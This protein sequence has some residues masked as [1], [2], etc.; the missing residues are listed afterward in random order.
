MLAVAI[1]LAA[2]SGGCSAFLTPAPAVASSPAPPACSTSY[3][4]PALDAA[5]ATGAAIVAYQTWPLRGACGNASCPP[6]SG[7]G[8]PL[9]AMVWIG[10]PLGYAASAVRGGRIVAVCRR[11]RRELTAAHA[12]WLAQQRAFAD[13]SAAIVA[14]R[15]DDCG[16]ALALPPGPGGV[17]ADPAVAQCRA[18][19]TERRR[20]AAAASARLA[21]VATGL[22]PAVRAALGAC[23]G[24][25]APPGP[26]RLQLA[27]DPAGAVTGVVADVGG[28]ALVA[29][30]TAALA[31]AR[32]PQHPGGHQVVV[33]VPGAA[34]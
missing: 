10:P 34:P 31:A 8:L 32:F 9:I 17:T 7:L 12:A 30:A 1:A 20:R 28:A 2:P 15:S 22:T 27:I 21:A 23:R 3:L 6:G 19:D 29:C 4:V 5:L 16:P 25:G 13:E 24:A 18:A 14:A 33:E 26:I 11:A